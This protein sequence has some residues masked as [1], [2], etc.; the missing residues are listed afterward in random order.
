MSAVDAT[1]SFDDV[2]HSDEA[3]SMMTEGSDS[4]IKFVGDIVGKMPKQSTPVPVCAAR[5]LPVPLQDA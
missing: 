5:G 4:G 3:R 1:E 2:G